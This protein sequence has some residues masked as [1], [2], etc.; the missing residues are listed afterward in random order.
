MAHTFNTSDLVSRGTKQALHAKAML[1][2]TTDHSYG[3][4][5]RQRK[6][7]S[8]QS[9]TIEIEPQATISTGRVG[10]LQDRKPKTVSAT[11]GQYNGV[12]ATTSIQKAFDQDGE[13]GVVKYG[14]TIGLRLVREIERTGFQ[15]AANYFGAAV[16]SPGAEP[17]SLRTWATGRARI[18]DQLAEGRVY[19]A[20]S[21]LAMVALA[22]SLKNATNPGKAISNQ[23]VSGQV[24]SLAGIDFYQCN[25]TYRHTA[26][27]ADNTTPLVDGAP[28]NGSNTL[29]ID[30]TTNGDIV[31]NA[32]HF[33][34][35]TVGASDA[36]YAVDQE[37]KQSLPYLQKFS[38]ISTSAA[39]SGSGDVDL[40]VSP[41]FYD[42]TD[43]RQNISQLP[44]D[45]ATITF[46]TVDEE[47]S[48]ANILY[49]P[50]AL[51]LITAPLASDSTGALKES[52]QTYGPVQIRTAIHPRDSINDQESLRVDAAWVWVAP[53]PEHGCVNWGA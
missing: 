50:S 11:I 4:D 30:G 28:T 36:V 15:H 12:F 18:D 25:S 16:G 20:M 3:A 5:L 44:A 29:H 39:S 53:R 19:G 9:I 43:S 23:N 27:T 21:P 48:Q 37:T 34:I 47:S 8:G 31:T 35:G 40:T 32:T 17:G 42:S 1:M 2:N 26:G 41:A 13:A 14:R 33:V 6:Y 45:G 38:V 52:F 46:D 24:K 22:D 7:I 10:V 49:A 51:S